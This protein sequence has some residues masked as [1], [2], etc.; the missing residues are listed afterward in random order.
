MEKQNTPEEE[1]IL[2]DSEKKQIE[3]YDGDNTFLK[4]LSDKF[5]EYGTLSPRQVLA[6]RNQGTKKPSLDKCPNTGLNTK[7]KCKFQEKQNVR[8][9]TISS[10]REKA[11]CMSDEK[12]NQYAWVPSKALQVEEYFIEETGETGFG[13]KLQDWFTRNEGFWKESVPYQSPP[14]K[15]EVVEEE[16][17]QVFDDR[18]GSPTIRDIHQPSSQEKNEEDELPF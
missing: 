7:Q 9:V 16:T 15:E 3:T 11:L 12:N 14:I 1:V 18:D 2:T 8:D 4:S 13:L 17:M 5:K 10:I 6:F